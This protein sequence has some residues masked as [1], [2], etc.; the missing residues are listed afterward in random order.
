MLTV[1]SSI[2]RFW[3]RRLNCY[4]TTS[5]FGSFA[6]KFTTPCCWLRLVICIGSTLEKACFAERSTIWCFLGLPG[7]ILPRLWFRCS[8]SQWRCWVFRV[9][10]LTRRFCFHT[11]LF[12]LCLLRLTL[13]VF[14]STLRFRCRLFSTRCWAFRFVRQKAWD[15]LGRF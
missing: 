11:Q 15:F 14:S 12:F 2:E 10:D 13:Q 5:V 1:S 3:L 7:F 4:F 9:L 8:F 6:C